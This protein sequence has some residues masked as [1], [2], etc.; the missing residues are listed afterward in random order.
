MKCNG[1]VSDTVLLKIPEYNVDPCISKLFVSVV[2]SNVQHYDAGT[3]FYSV[4]FKHAGKAL[5]M[6]IS[7]EKW[8]AA[9]YLDYDGI[10]KF[11]QFSFLLRG[12]L[13]QDSIFKKINSVPLKILLR[14]E[15]A[16]SSSRFFPEPSL[17][18][19]YYICKPM[20]INL[21]IYTKGSIKDFDMKI[22]SPQRE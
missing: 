21:E 5:Y 13:D 18:G 15:G 10:L 16:D 2:K 1:Q 3:F 8:T 17:Q 22:R 12:D 6:N 19:T 4:T 7:T 14:K 9:P 20:P 11:R